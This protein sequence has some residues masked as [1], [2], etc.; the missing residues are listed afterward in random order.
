MN[1]FDSN[2]RPE[3]FP[4]GSAESRAAARLLVEKRNTALIPVALVQI[5]NM[6]APM[7]FERD[8]NLV[9]SDWPCWMTR[10]ELETKQ[11]EYVKYEA[12]WYAQ[13]ERERSCDSAEAPTLASPDVPSVPIRE[14]SII[15]AT[16]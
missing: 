12:A 16:A 10:H 9:G 3:E 2:P 11:R 4:L 13:I 1:P 6:G 7:V 14:E 15:D 5:S 8:P